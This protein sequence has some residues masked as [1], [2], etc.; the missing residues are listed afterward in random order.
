[1]LEDQTVGETLQFK[2]RAANDSY[3]PFSSAVTVTVS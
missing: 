1:V 3:A 2:I